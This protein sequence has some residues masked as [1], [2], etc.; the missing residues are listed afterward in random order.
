MINQLTEMKN[1]YIYIYYYYIME[2]KKQMNLCRRHVL[3]EAEIC[4][5]YAHYTYLRYYYII[6]SF[7]R[8]Y[9]IFIH[10]SL[11]RNSSNNFR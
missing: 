6:N 4:V 9:N 5:H 7:R 2:K 10:C 1:V 3:E 8:M 11:R